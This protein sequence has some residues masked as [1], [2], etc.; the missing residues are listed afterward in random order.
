M[1]DDALE[2]RWGQTGA[3]NGRTFWVSGAAQ[4]KSQ[5]WKGMT[6]VGRTESWNPTCMKGNEAGLETEVPGSGAL[7]SA[8]GNGESEKGSNI[9]PDVVTFMEGELSQDTA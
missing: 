9:G 7:A 4:E 3:E 8:E 5:K 2:D 6:W 1:S